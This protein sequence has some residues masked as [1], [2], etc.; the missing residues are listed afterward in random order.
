MP[1]KSFS[2]KKRLS[3]KVTRS[4]S[5]SKS[6]SRK[7]RNRKRMVKKSNKRGGGYIGFSFDFLDRIVDMPALQRIFYK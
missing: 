3:K 1:R 7:N 5:R 6:N 2:S 4:K